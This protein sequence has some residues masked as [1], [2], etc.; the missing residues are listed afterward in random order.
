M[1]NSLKPENQVFLSN[2]LP[3]ELPR[4]LTLETVI[5]IMALTNGSAEKG[6][7]FVNSE[8]R[9]GR[10]DP[11]PCGCGRKYKYCPVFKLDPYIQEQIFE[12][13][14]AREERMEKSK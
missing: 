2:S 4:R 10:N 8:E 7:T 5:A 14:R 11:C 13:A 12:H 3:T 1:L 9:I 6:T